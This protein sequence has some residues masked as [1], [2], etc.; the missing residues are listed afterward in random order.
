MLLLN[1]LSITQRH[2]IGSDTMLHK[3]TWTPLLL[4][5]ARSIQSSKRA[6]WRGGGNEPSGISEPL[7]KIHKLAING[8]GTGAVAATSTVTG[9]LI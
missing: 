6:Y 4:G 8:T 5:E 7:P 3:R 1:L 9:K 2:M